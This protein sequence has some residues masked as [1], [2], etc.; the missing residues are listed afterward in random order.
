M[1]Y[2][3][4]NKPYGVLSQFTAEG[5][6]HPTLKDYIPVPNVYAAGRLDRDSEGLLLMTDDGVLI[7]RLSEPGNHVWKQYWV[8]V[9]G[10]FSPQGLTNL[11]NG[12]ALKGYQTL[13]CRVQPIAEPA[14]AP[15]EKPVTPHGPTFWLDIKLREGKKRQIRHMTAVVGWFTLRLVRWAIGGVTLEN[16]APGTWRELGREDLDLLWPEEKRRQR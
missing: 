16:L 3:I 8:Q 7:N 11:Q 6:G 2:L 13:P 5:T 14:L 10:E 15:R 1:R 9:E 4:F 12:V